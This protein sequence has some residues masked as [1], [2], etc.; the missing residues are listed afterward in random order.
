[1]RPQ[2]LGE[3]PESFS[4]PSI[5][6]VALLV[7]VCHCGWKDDGELLEGMRPKCAKFQLRQSKNRW[8]SRIIASSLR[9]TPS[10]PSCRSR[11]PLLFHRERN[12]QHPYADS[13]E[14]RGGNKEYKLRALSW[15]VEAGRQLG[16]V[17]SGRHNK[18]SRNACCEWG[19]RNSRCLTGARYCSTRKSYFRKQFQV[20]WS[21]IGGVPLQKYLPFGDE[22]VYLDETQSSKLWISSYMEN[23]N[24]LLM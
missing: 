24:I 8:W 16:S 7:I 14:S 5:V 15:P 17:R 6:V 20:S 4:E 23:N 10:S 2:T 3:V 13:A 9:S 19:R 21:R 18:R 11:R 22:W 12:S 1:M